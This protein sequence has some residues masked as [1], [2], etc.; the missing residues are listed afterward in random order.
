MK[1]SSLT[2]QER[3]HSLVTHDRPRWPWRL[4]VIALGSVLLT[5]CAAQP[6]ADLPEYGDSVRRM[7]ELQTY[8]PEDE[9]GTMRGDKPAAAMRAYRQPPTSGQ[10]S[11]APM[12]VM[13]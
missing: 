10:A 11:Q 1:R 3:T 8:P 13:P 9:V 5:A 6:G 7:I 2:P 4:A 12:V